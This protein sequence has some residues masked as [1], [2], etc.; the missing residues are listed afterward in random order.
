[1]KQNIAREL[2]RR[3]LERKNLAAYIVESAERLDYKIYLSVLF[4]MVYGCI[5]VT[6]ASSVS[7]GRKQLVFCVG[8]CIIMAGLS[9]LNYMWLRRWARLL[10]LLA[11]G[12]FVLLKVPGLGVANDEGITRWLALGPFQFQVAEA[13]KLCLIIFIADQ[14]YHRWKKRNHLE[15]IFRLWI[16]AAI[17]A[18]EAV[19]I[20]SNLSSALILL[21]LTFILTAVF[22][23]TNKLHLGLIALAAAGVGMLAFYLKSNMP[24][25]SELDNWQ[26]MLRRVVVWLDPERYSSGSGYQVMLGLY[27]IGSGGLFGKGLG[28]GTNK[29]ILPEAHNDLILAVIGEELGVVGILMLSAL[30]AYLFYAIIKVA[31]N[32]EEIFGKMLAAGV[33]AHLATQVL[34]NIAVVTSVMPN[35]GVTLPFISYGGSSIL[36]LSAEIGMVLSVYRERAR[37]GY[38]NQQKL[39]KLQDQT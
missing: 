33:M 2:F 12:L 35:T 1:M 17:M 25:Q 37:R 26:Y 16:Y 22:T 24:T 3:F 11:L 15:E 28:N 7:T 23:N 20:S 9:R 6:S 4:L 34:M 18:A 30:Y 29:A 19:L 10:Y 38:R 39:R 36:C 21:M 27:G 14:M 5:M 32:T 31:I 13:A 8:G